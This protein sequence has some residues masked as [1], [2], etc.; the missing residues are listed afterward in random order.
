[1]LK[2]LLLATMMLFSAAAAAQPL[3]EVNLNPAPY[4]R[5]EAR[6]QA[7]SLILDRLTGDR[8]RDSWVLDEALREPERYLEAEPQGQGY[9]AVFSQDELLTLLQSAEL[10]FSLEPRPALLVWQLDNGTARNEADADWQQAASAYRLPLL[11]P[12]W[13][14]QEHME[15]DKAQLFDAGSL[16]QAS[17]RYGAD[18]WLALERDAQGGR[19]QLFG[20]EQDEALLQGRLEP[21]EQAMMTLA[22]ALNRYWVQPSGRREQS[23]AENPEP[24]QPLRLEQDGPGELT[25]VVSGLRQFSDSIRLEQRLRRLNGVEQA[26]VM[27][28]A[29]HQVRYRL[30]VASR[31]GVLRALT[32]VPGL[33]AVTEREFNWSGT[34]SE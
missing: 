17:R 15:I 5:E 10:P 16:R 6:E 2:N 24:A 9:T 21:G 1:M 14:L 12:L 25:I 22:A 30:L 34:A 29:G 19:W 13:D 7:L 11:W 20:A 31:D 23:R 27:D 28:S 8:A 4:S 18:Y 33:V 3:L 32:G 26:Y